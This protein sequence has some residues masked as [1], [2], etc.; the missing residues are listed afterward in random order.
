MF[1]VADIADEA[2]KIIGACSEEQF[3]AW[4]TDVV[5]MIA[6]K[7]DFEPFKGMIDICT[8]GCACASSGATCHANPCGRRCVTLPR[9]VST[10]LA[11]NIG[12]HPALGFGQTFE[13][14]LNT[15]GK[16]CAGACEFNWYDQGGYH[17]LFRDLI[18]PAH[19]VAHL[20][21]AEDNGKEVIVQGFDTDGN[22]L[23]RQVNGEWI[24]GILLPTIFGYALPDAEQPMIARITRLSKSDTVGTVRVSTIDSSGATGVTLSIM[25]PDETLPQLRRIKLSKV[26]DW[27]RI[28]YRRSN[29]KFTSRYDHVP[30]QSR[31]AFLLGMQARKHYRDL[32]IND[33]HAYESDAARLEVEA[34]ICAEPPTYAPLQV[35]DRSQSLVDRGDLDIV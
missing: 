8:A 11:V 17:Y 20:Q 4:S 24:N 23:R 6:Q 13:F 21:T 22:A 29:P 16:G 26:C 3:L 1:T 34:Q 30:L 31:L 35:Y 33:A 28:L 5:Q 7:G 2:R 12:G 18:T 10:V 27:V 14:H 9:E 32:Q 19:L 15:S 25:E